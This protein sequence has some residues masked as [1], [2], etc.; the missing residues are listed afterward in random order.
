MFLNLLITNMAST[1]EH[2]YLVVAQVLHM[3][4]ILSKYLDVDLRHLFVE[5]G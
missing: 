5:A 4:R 3:L 1:R 2:L